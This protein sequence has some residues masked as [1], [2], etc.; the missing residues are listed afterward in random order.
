MQGFISLLLKL[1]QALEP[2]DPIH[3]LSSPLES[4]N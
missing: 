3:R 4:E 2:A 1:C